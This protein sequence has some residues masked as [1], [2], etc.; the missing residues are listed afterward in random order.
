[1]VFRPTMP[2]YH[3]RPAED[4][5]AVAERVNDE[6]IRRFSAD[7]PGLRLAP[8]VVVIP[9]FNEEEA[10]GGVLERIPAEACGLP[11]DTIVVDDGSDDRTAAIAGEHAAYVAHRARNAGQGAAFR[12]DYRLA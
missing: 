7:H 4:G 6:A 11:V 5:K 1:M 10:I 8:V 9:A 3:G 2:I 12:V